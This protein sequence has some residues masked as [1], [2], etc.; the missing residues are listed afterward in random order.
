MSKKINRIYSGVLER[1]SGVLE[2]YSGVL[3]RYR[4]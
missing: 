4:T 1:Y 2:R 3:E